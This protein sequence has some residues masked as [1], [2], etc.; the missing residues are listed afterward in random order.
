MYAVPPRAASPACA[1][2]IVSA[3]GRPP[4][5]V[6]PRPA[7]LPWRETM[8]Q[9]TAG[10]GATRPNPLAASASAW[11]MCSESFSGSKRSLPVATLHFPYQ[12]LKV[13]GLAEIA[14]D[15]G[16]AD[17]GDLVETCE[18]LHHELTNDLGGNFVFAHA[19][20]P[21]NDAG[22]HAIHALGFNRPFS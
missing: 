7:I 1:S 8:T 3:C 10:L 14:I 4:R 22:H 13:L 6:H 11:R 19:L 12:G 16:E 15:G 21:A 20:K 2:A 17:I 18:S 5:A 9:P